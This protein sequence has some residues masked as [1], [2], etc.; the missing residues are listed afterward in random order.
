MI[1]IEFTNRSN[2]D[3]KT[4]LSF[5]IK[6]EF[7]VTY[8]KFRKYPYFLI[9]ATII[10]LGLLQFTGVN[11]FIT[12]KSVSIFVLIISWIF[13]IIYITTILIKWFKRQLW[14]QKSIAFSLKPNLGYI[15][16]F[17]EE[18]IAFTTPTY[19]TEF[20]WE[21]Y[22]YW[23]EN[24]NSIFIFPPNSI[25]DAVYFSTADLGNENYKQLKEIASS[26]LINLSR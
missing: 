16:Y 6:K 21:Y 12:L 7:Y 11:N 8:Y 1:Q 4:Q 19:K 2:P 14:K 15:F 26:K 13:A 25:Y 5:L 9:G 10:L 24:N 20:V 22:K 3:Y 23:V 18:K 17:D